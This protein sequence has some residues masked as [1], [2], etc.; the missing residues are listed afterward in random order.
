MAQRRSRGVTSRE[1]IAAFM[2]RALVEEKEIT[3]FN[4]GTSV[5]MAWEISAIRYSR[6]AQDWLDLTPADGILES[7]QD[8]QAVTLTVDRSGLKPG[9]HRATVTVTALKGGRQTL[10]V[11]VW[12]PL[13]GRGKN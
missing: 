12:V 11:W 5:D 8:G 2:Q 6:R 3:L 9:I 4:E 1:Q 7:G 13:L 10:R